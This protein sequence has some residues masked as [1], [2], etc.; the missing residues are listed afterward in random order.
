MTIL[1]FN[2]LFEYGNTCLR[3]T[4][5]GTLKI[6]ICRS[7]YARTTQKRPKPISPGAESDEANPGSQYSRSRGV[8][9]GI[10]DD[11]FYRISDTRV[12][13]AHF[14]ITNHDGTANMPVELMIDSGA[15]SEL[16][17]PGRKVIQLKLKP[18][19]Q[20]VT[21]RG[22][23]NHVSS[24][25]NFSP[26]LVEATFDRDG[27]QEKLRHIYACVPTRPNATKPWR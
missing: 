3:L 12:V 10:R 20:P 5:Y 4:A 26:V 24:V 17:L 18:V 13:R 23:T 9:V 7:L 21:T 14:N 8:S 22:S 27:A 16:K 11:N 15:R 25:L 2:L 1:F 19:G 6:D